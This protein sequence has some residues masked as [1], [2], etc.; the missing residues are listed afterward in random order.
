M[1]MKGNK[2]GRGWWGR[3]AE[4][5]SVVTGCDVRLPHPEDEGTAILLTDG[6]YPPSDPALHLGRRTFNRPIVRTSD[7]PRRKVFSDWGKFLVDVYFVARF[8]STGGDGKHQV[9][10]V[11]IV[12]APGLGTPL[13]VSGSWRVSVVAVDS[14]SLCILLLFYSRQLECLWVESIFLAAGLCHDCLSDCFSSHRPGNSGVF[15]IHF[16]VTVDY[17]ERHSE[18]KHRDDARLPFVKGL[19]DTSACD[20][21]LHIPWFFRVGIPYFTFH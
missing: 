8:Q 6:Y 11:T 10:A 17:D 20:H 14:C 13:C 3:K 21:F 9:L 12:P 4:G 18:Y 19:A 1:K 16:A 5:S 2:E 15:E 7:F